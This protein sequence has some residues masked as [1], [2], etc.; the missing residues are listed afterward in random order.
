MKISHELLSPGVS[1]LGLGT[2]LKYGSRFNLRVGQGSLTWSVA[3][4]HGPIQAD[5]W[6]DC[7]S[8]GLQ[9]MYTHYLE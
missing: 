6:K 1:L 5:L 2:H 4:L 9:C 3:L 7:P 8:P